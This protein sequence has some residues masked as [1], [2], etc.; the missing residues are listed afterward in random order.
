MPD[1]IAVSDDSLDLL[2]KSS[3]YVLLDLWAP[4][5]QPCLALAPLLE[6]L[7]RQASDDFTVAKLNVDLY[8]NVQQRLAVRGIPGLLL[9]K[10][11][12][13]VSRQVGVKTLTQLRIW[14]DA[15]GV[16]LNETAAA[17]VPSRT[18]WPA[19]YNDA[20]L[21]AFLSDRLKKHAL[22]H[23]IKPGFM[24]YWN[25]NQGTIS[26]AIAHH[27][28]PQVFER[29]TGLP[30]GLAFVLENIPFTRPDEI[31]ALFTVLTP[32]KDVSRV[33][34]RWI[35]E[36]LSDRYFD[37]SDWLQ[38]TALN[39]LRQQ[40]LHLAAQHLN[41]EML[42]PAA[43]A[44]LVGSTGDE[45]PF[46][47][48]GYGL[49]SSLATILN[50]LSPPPEAMD[51]AAWGGIKIQL[52]FA[53]AEMIKLRAGWTPDDRAAPAIRE[54]WFNAR[55]QQEPEKK[56]TERRLQELRELWLAENTAFAA[57][58]EALYAEYATQVQR[59]NAPLKESLLHL[60]ADAPAFEAKA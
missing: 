51:I 18:P 6:T 9:F 53:L 37:W 57:R 60:L 26:A 47:Q 59:L 29:I 20:S 8:P 33:P 52:G 42:P 56:F 13:E 14:L 12:Q 27:E 2:L 23:E 41:D 32:G 1:I 25:D 44:Q 35:Q 40:W 24:P 30:A 54:L 21:H 10:K 28:D 50:T 4:W 34:L 55:Q 46:Q 58:E 43:W 38:S 17:P 11:G 45:Q 3:P 19:F 36:V 7:A 49:E 22:A 39:A 16:A 15:E 5:C 31:E 48:P